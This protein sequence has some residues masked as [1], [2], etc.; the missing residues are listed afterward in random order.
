MTVVGIHVLAEQRDFTNARSDQISRLAQDAFFGTRNLS[1]ARIGHHAEG[2]EFI[3]AFLNGQERGR[4]T[5]GAGTFV[6]GVEFVFFGEI[7]IDRTFAALHGFFHL[8]EA[9][10]GLRS[11][12]QVHNRCT[13]HDL[14]AFGLR[15]TASNADFQIRVHVL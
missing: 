2:A 13:R 7:R 4:S 15:D 6:Q 3:A 12:D 5:G 1:P 14:F 11:D 8:W 9:V 10:V